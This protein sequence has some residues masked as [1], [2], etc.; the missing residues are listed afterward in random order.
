MRSNNNKQQKGTVL[1]TG[2]STGI[3]FS[4]AI[5]LDNLGYRVYAGVRK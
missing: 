4:T 2:A 3:G 1:I 5:Y